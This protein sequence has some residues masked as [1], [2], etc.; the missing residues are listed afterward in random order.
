[1]P[2]STIS[3]TYFTQWC[4]EKQIKCR[5]IKRAR[6]DGYKR[7]DFAINVGEHW[8]VVEVKQTDP[9]PQ[10]KNLLE[11]VSTKKEEIITGWKV[12]PGSRLLRGLREATTQLRRFS[13]RG[14]P[15]VV[16]FFD[17]TLGFYDT[18]RDVNQGNQK[19]Q[20]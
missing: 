17:N 7:P 20:H 11:R 9:N 8:C 15:T 1:M 5:R 19:I 10:D 14:L 18:P 12:S 4:Y 16:C 6:A 13:M 3:E 2:E